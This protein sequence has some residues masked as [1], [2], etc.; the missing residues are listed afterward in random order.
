MGKNTI[1][2]TKRLSIAGIK[3]HIWWSWYELAYCH[4]NVC[5]CVDLT[6]FS[7]H[8]NLSG[9]AGIWMVIQFDQSSYSN[10]VQPQSQNKLN[11]TL[12]GLLSA[13]WFPFPL[14]NSWNC[15]WLRIPNAWLSKQL[16]A[17]KRGNNSSD[18]G[19]GSQSI[20]DKKMKP[21]SFLEP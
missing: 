9:N 17:S 7:L 12:T 14:L 16:V 5:V 18:C 8:Q 13:V 4:L 11:R 10:N 3:K 1:Q 20:E 15:L 6:P 2:T 19:N 21:K